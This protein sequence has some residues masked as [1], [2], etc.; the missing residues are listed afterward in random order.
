MIQCQFGQFFIHCVIPSIFYRGITKIREGEPAETIQIQ[1][2]GISV[3]IPTFGR[4]LNQSIIFGI[5][6][7]GRHMIIVKITNTFIK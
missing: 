4:V 6:C 2:L 1:F 7:D 5:I 3:C